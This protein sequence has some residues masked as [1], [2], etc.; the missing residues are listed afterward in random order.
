[1]NGRREKE[2]SRKAQ[3]KV[4]TDRNN[5][6]REVGFDRGLTMEWKMQCAMMAQNKDDAEQHHRDMHMIMITKQIESTEG[7]VESKLKTSERMSSG[8]SE[9]QVFSS[10]NLLMEKLERL[11]GDLETMMNEKWTT[12]PIIGNVLVTAAKAMG[13]AKGDEDINVNTDFVSDILNEL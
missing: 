13:L 2:R 11:N 7:L 12:H 4:A 10:I 9:A 5:V 1:L 6:D 3:R 8:G